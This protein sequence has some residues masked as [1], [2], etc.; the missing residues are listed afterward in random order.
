[1][2]VSLSDYLRYTFK[3]NNIIVPLSTELQFAEKYVEIMKYR[4]GDKI[5]FKMN[6]DKELDNINVI[7]L[8]IQPIIE[9][10]IYHGIVPS[11]NKTETITVST[12]RKKQ[13]AVVC[14]E[15]T[16]KIISD[17]DIKKIENMINDSSNSM[18]E[19]IGIINVDKRIKYTFGNNYGIRVSTDGNTTR[20]ELLFPYS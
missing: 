19:H 8:S 20:F 6:H 18:D 11:E 5:S 15:N 16:G 17:E 1:M 9:N 12:F 3:I 7:K 14:I 2:L 13:F 4:Y 10:A